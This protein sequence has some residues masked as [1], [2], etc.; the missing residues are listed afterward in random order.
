MQPNPNPQEI[1]HATVHVDR[2]YRDPQPCG[3]AAADEAVPQ[4]RHPTPL[5]SLAH[6]RAAAGATIELQTLVDYVRCLLTA[7]PP[8]A[9]PM[10]AAGGAV[11]PSHVPSA[12]SGGERKER[13]KKEKRQ[14]FLRKRKSKGV[15]RMTPSPAPPGNTMNATSAFNTNVLGNLSEWY[16]AVNDAFQTQNQRLLFG[17]DDEAPPSGDDPTR[18][19]DAEGAQQT[20]ALLRSLLCKMGNLTHPTDLQERYRIPRPAPAEQHGE[21]GEA[22]DAEGNETN[23]NWV[24]IQNMYTDF[25]RHPQTNV[26]RILL[27]IFQPATPQGGASAAPAEA[28]TRSGASARL[29]TLHRKL[30]EDVAANLYFCVV[31]TNLQTL[32]GPL[33]A[34][35]PAPSLL[36]AAFSYLCFLLLQKGYNRQKRTLHLM[37]SMLSNYALY[38][39]V[40]ALLVDSFEEA[41]QRGEAR[42]GPINTLEAIIAII[43][44]AHHYEDEDITLAWGTFF[45]NLLTFPPTVADTEVQERSEV[46]KD[47]LLAAL[48]A[49]EY[50]FVHLTQEL[51]LFARHA[52][53]AATLSPDRGAPPKKQ[54]EIAGK[55][56]TK[57]SRISKLLFK[58]LLLLSHEVCF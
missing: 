5:S 41:R 58:I 56:D 25:T 13:D 57:E 48:L 35:A 33:D 29:A 28:S 24:A 8:A 51:L 52:P 36:T 37:L 27:D 23:G 1:N 12:E 17:L 34:D 47:R 20:L 43:F 4:T 15:E 46:L 53:A 42:E 31:L 2:A 9:A 55:E 18:S 14:S 40:K 44:T 39:P 54:K 49:E 7:P 50:H 3:A 16:G 19:D 30:Q 32:L 11:Q 38:M 22:G 26:C 6:M 45:L 21:R 10:E